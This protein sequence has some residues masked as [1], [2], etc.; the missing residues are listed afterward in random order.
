MLLRTAQM[1]QS[2]TLLFLLLLL[3]LLLLAAALH[4]HEVA[5]ELQ[6][7][8]ALLGELAP[9]SLRKSPVTLAAAEQA[10]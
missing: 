2:P 6:P 8:V 10:P 7:P 1:Q 9:V 5:E 3:M 4:W